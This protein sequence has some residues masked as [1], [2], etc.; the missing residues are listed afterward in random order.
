[1]WDQVAILKDDKALIMQFD[2][3]DRD[4]T[5]VKCYIYVYTQPVN[6]VCAVNTSY[7]TYYQ[8]CNIHIYG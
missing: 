1:M 6:A 4:V 8:Y 2:I 3:F 5:I 7:H